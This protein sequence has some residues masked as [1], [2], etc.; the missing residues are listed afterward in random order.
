VPV[1]PFVVQQCCADLGGVVRT[2][3]LALAG[4]D[5]RSLRLAVL[6]GAV[7]RLREGVY[8]SPDTTAAVRVSVTHGGAL[9][10]LSRLTAAGLW[11]LDDDTTVHVSMPRN[12]RARSHEGC[13]CVVH[14]SAAQQWGGMV[15]VVDALAQ[16]LGCRGEE[17]FFVSLESA[18]RTR[19][20]DRVGVARLRGLIP[21]KYRWLVDFARW[22]ADSGLESLL[23]LR[24][25]RH[26]ISLA[27]QV[28]I[29]GVGWVDF[30]LGDRLILEVDG[31]PN[32]VG[33]SMRHKDLV[34]D[35]VA[36]AHGFDTLR[37][38]YAMVVHEWEL[39]EAAILAR[40]E[41]G[42]HRRVRVAGRIR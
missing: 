24:L 39:V 3:D 10:C 25:R 26:G 40:T 35:A 2:R 42:L 14:W 15:S 7:L 36:A 29:P 33:A 4:V 9:G 32:H 20:I 22:N 17:A 31:K 19:A 30:V 12:G 5:G 28:A 8:A 18:M 1:E 37:F 38:D 6:A 21:S 11:V 23:R 13:S 16:A 34:R 27:S 41:R